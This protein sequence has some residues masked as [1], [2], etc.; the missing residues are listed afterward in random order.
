MFGFADKKREFSCINVNQNLFSDF[1]DNIRLCPKGQNGIIRENFDGLWFDVDDLKL[2]RQ[3]LSDKLK[4]DNGL[5]ICENCEYRNTGKKRTEKE[6]KTLILGHW[7]KCILDCSYCN[8][9]KSIGNKN[10]NHYGITPVIERLTDE[11]IVTRN[12]KIIFRCGD[13]TLHPEFDKLLYYFINFES[14]NIEVHSPALTY[15]D[16]IAD[17]IGRNIV[18]LVVN[19]DCG[20]K[21][22]YKFIKKEEL[23]DTTIENI[24]RYMKFQIPG[25]KRI[26]SKFNLILGAND[27]KKEITDWFI[28]S[29]DLGIKKVMIDTDEN[30]YLALCKDMPDY[31]KEMTVFIKQISELNE[32]DIVFCDKVKLLYSRI[33]NPK[34]YMVR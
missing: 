26:I 21:N 28:L 3:N 16:S 2:K 23:F 33:D 5:Q 17:G 32:I 15:R 12:T 18:N 8:L 34:K 31:I 9:K 22:V 4:S 11:K 13:S 14:K 10:V 24:K 6:I 19:L 1:S 25:E 27:S 29:Q 7:K 20:N 30:T